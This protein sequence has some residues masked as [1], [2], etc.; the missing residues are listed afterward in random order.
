M[1]I[2]QQS[3]KRPV[4]L[5]IRH[6]GSDRSISWPRA[7]RI[8]ILNA[9]FFVLLSALAYFSR[10]T[11]FQASVAIAVLYFLGSLYSSYL[12]TRSGYG[13]SAANFFNLGAGAGF[14]FGT[15]YST[16][17]TDWAA[18]A[19][20]AANRQAEL[21][22]KINLINA[23]AVF[24]VLLSAWLVCRTTH[25]AAGRKSDLTGAISRLASF[26]APLLIG[27]IVITA[28]QLATF[29]LP[30]NL[31][32]R[33]LL[34]NTSVIIY[35]PI[36]ISA[37]QWQRL[38]TGKK[39]SIAI[40][41]FVSAG[42]GVLELSKT[43]MLLPF[44]ALAGGFMFDRAHWRKLFILCS[45][46]TF[47]YFS[48]FAT[49]V[50]NGRNHP[51]YDDA[52]NSMAERMLIVSE[53]WSDTVARSLSSSDSGTLLSRFAHA[54]TQSFLIERYDVGNPGHTLDDAWAALVPR[55]LWPD[56]PIIT[57]F[58]SE[59]DG[60][61]AQ[62]NFSQSSL[63]PTFSAEA[64]WND[65]WLGL[66]LISILLGL[67]IGW[68]TKKWNGLARR[69]HSKIG[70]LVFAVPVILSASRVEAWVVANCVGGFATLA[71]LIEAADFGMP[72]LLPR[73]KNVAPAFSYRLRIER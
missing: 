66:A 11:A 26:R 13:L 65:G 19:F 52:N 12:I 36:L 62:R 24:L 15:V 42:I 22:P 17:R 67:E 58:G 30:E 6:G 48:I 44:F 2:R 46:L 59:L 53:T 63:A 31:L 34:S 7:Y 45:V 70:I 29:P 4:G 68:F 32:V 39:I 38:N 71:I 21:L 25:D 72:L 37:M 41:I 1:I 40:L 16:S 14:G 5:Q 33:T 28:L 61:F 60:L 43:Q 10:T 56:K 8:A 3:G 35:L 54:P 51:L 73:S 27:A 57:R 9:S 55:L 64:Y 18:Q 50:N 49:I 20:F 23:V 69:E 47:A